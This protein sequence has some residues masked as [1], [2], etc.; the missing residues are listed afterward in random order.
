MGSEELCED[1]QGKCGGTERRQEEGWRLCNK[2][3][4]IA[5]K[6]SD[7][8]LRAKESAK[9]LKKRLKRLLFCCNKKKKKKN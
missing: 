4:H 6:T 3:Q 8:C 9:A 1:D 5:I 7:L 2:H